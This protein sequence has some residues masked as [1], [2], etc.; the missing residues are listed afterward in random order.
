MSHES[1]TSYLPNYLTEDQVPQDI[2]G[3]AVETP[4]GWVGTVMQKTDE[5]G[6]RNVDFGRGDVGTRP[7]ELLRKRVVRIPQAN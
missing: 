4:I 3:C 5:S 6:N 7:E 1:G 2:T